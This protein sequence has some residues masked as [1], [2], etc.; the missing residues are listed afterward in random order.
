ML[1]S[2]AVAVDS[3]RGGVVS[4]DAKVPVIGGMGVDGIDTIERDFLHTNL[5][6]GNERIIGRKGNGHAYTYFS[7]A[8]EVHGWFLCCHE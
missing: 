8:L 2:I 4:Q 7:I 6:G 1:G 5:K 3:P